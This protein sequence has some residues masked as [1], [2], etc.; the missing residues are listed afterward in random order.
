LVVVAVVGVGV[1]SVVSGV[2]TVVVVV[3]WRGGREVA[4]TVVVVSD[5]LAGDAAIRFVMHCHTK[6]T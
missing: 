4:S 1:G 2:L 6:V 5:E 3:E